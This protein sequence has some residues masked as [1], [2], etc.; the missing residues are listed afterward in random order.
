[1]GKDGRNLEKLVRIVEEVYKTNPETK[2]YSNYKI[3]NESGN[4]REI[5]ILIESKVNGFDVKIAIECKEFKSKVSVE[6]IEAFNSKCQR[7]PSIN[8]KIF[9]SQVG[10]QKDAIAAAETFGIK[11]YTFDQIQSNASSILFPISRIKPVFHGF[12]I[13]EIYCDDHP[14]LSQ[15]KINNIQELQLIS[16]SGEKLVLDDLLEEAVKP[17]WKYINW[18]AFSNWLKDSSTTHKIQFAVN[19]EGI[20]F[21]FENEKILVNQLVCNAKINFEFMSAEVQAKE[22][23][24]FSNGEIKAQTIS[25]DDG[26]YSGSVVIDEA[27]KAHFFDTTDNKIRELKLLAKYDKNTDSFETFE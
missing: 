11:L 7:I 12:E 22:Y 13:E 14:K 8:N 15:I 9:V 2:I 16:I 24:S 26:L 5:D 21:E 19:F 10:F 25:F 20:F 18:Q 4:K 6:K 17:N 1:M 3:P 27:N 23:K